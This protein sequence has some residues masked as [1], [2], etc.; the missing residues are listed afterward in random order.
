MSLVSLPIGPVDII[1]K[2]ADN[3]SSCIR[4]CKVLKRAVDRIFMAILKKD[5]DLESLT[6]YS[7]YQRRKFELL[8]GY[9]QI[10]H[11]LIDGFF[12]FIAFSSKYY[13]YD[14]PET[15]VRNR[16]TNQIVSKISEVPMQAFRFIS[17]SCLLVNDK[18]YDVE[19][20]DEILGPTA[21]T[22]PLDVE[23]QPFVPYPLNEVQIKRVDHVYALNKNGHLHLFDT[24]THK[25]TQ[26]SAPFS[27]DTYIY[28]K[29]GKLLLYRNFTLTEH[30]IYNDR[31]RSK[32]LVFDFGHIVDVDGSY[33]MIKGKYSTRIHHLI[34]GKQLHEF[35][36]QHEW[37]I[38]GFD[39]MILRSQ[40]DFDTTRKTYL[41]GYFSA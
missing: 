19:K 36:D 7:T 41:S 8:N 9:P 23:L 27:D 35:E 33:V 40:E 12:T 15:L 16:A 6:P 31:L 13:A 11:K 34:S 10:S 29:K 2:Y 24:E 38:C 3:Y 1:L 25:L 18:V 4:T 5:F 21:L 20:Q 37:S 30:D 14:T 17:P 26:T 32:S 39:C 22:T 28:F